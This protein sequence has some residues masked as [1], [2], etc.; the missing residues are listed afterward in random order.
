MGLLDVLTGMRNGPRGA[1]GGGA[2][3]PITMALLGLLAYKAVKG[4]SAS[5]PAG[6]GMAPA[7]G[8][9][10]DILRDAF[11]KAGQGGLGSILNGGLSDLLKQFQGAGKSDVADSWVGR[12]ANKQIGPGDLS[13]ILTPDQIAFLSERTGLTREQLLAG[14]AA[15]LPAAVDELTPQGRLPAPDEFDRPA[16]KTV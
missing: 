9:L 15:Q 13:R 11:G 5:K 10:G 7:G 1:G 4:F 6:P 14:L 3:S 16:G 12:D 2:M 8:G